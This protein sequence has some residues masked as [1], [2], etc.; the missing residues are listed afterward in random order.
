MNIKEI[1]RSWFNSFAGSDEQKELALNRL[2]IC[3]ACEEIKTNA[4]NII[5]CGNCGCPISKKIF[6]PIYN[7]CPLKKWEESDK[8]YTDILK[9]KL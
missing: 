6:S 9:D 4:A 5:V 3:N 8:N 2:E 7:S 1:V